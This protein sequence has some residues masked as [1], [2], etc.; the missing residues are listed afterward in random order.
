LLEQTLG[1]HRRLDRVQH[2][3]DARG[4]LIEEDQVRGGERLER[5][6]L[7]DGLHVP[8]K[9]QRQDHNT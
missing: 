5:G 7:D 4:E 6:Q 9:K 2:D 1:A 3:A 8:F